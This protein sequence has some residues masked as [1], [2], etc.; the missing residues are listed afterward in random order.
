MQSRFGPVHSHK[1]NFEKRNSNA[2]KFQNKA[3]KHNQKIKFQNGP[4]GLVFGHF[5]F[6]PPKKIT[7]VVFFNNNK[8]EIV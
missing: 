1:K 3:S 5:A 8:H 4:L 7:N 2:K 6:I